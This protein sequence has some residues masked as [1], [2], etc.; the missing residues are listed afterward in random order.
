MLVWVNARF[1][2]G[3]NHFSRALARAPRVPD[4]D[5]R[6]RK[7]LPL[8]LGGSRLPLPPPLSR[9][10]SLLPY[11]HLNPSKRTCLASAVYSSN[12]PCRMY[13]ALQ[14]TVTDTMDL[15]TGCFMTFL[16]G[17]VK[18]DIDS[19]NA[20]FQISGPL[21]NGPHKVSPLPFFHPQH[22]RIP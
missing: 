11:P 3:S 17:G 21:S 2:S 14:H 22:P 5:P 13:A 20:T 8:R 7:Q 9:S 4:L 16:I 18:R 15:A 19:I 12:S 1:W 10:G 6:R